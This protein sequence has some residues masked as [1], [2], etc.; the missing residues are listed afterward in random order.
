MITCQIKEAENGF[1]L[2]V[3]SVDFKTGKGSTELLICPDLRTL[4]RHVANAAGEKWDTKVITPN[5]VPIK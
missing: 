2:Q 3:E 4:F 5:I 1:V